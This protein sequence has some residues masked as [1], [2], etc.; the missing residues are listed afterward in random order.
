MLAAV[1]LIVSVVP[2]TAYSQEGEATSTVQN[3]DATDESTETEQGGE[4]EEGTAVS[5][6]D[7]EATDESTETEQDDG[8]DVK[9]ERCVLQFGK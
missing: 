9:G 6:Q 2:S 7:V 1:M 8:I 4:T 5:V 3:M